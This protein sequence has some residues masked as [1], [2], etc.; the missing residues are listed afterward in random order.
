MKRIQLTKTT[1]RWQA[2]RLDLRTGG[3]HPRPTACASRAQRLTPGDDHPRR[4]VPLA[5]QLL[6]AAPAGH[7]S[8]CDLEVPDVRIT[9]R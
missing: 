6:L 2:P 3:G 8:C 1:G 9:A 4:T 5:E 7:A